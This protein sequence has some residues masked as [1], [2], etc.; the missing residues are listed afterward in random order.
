MS[1]FCFLWT[2]LFY[3]FW[4]SITQEISV[5][6]GGIWALLLG[7]V[8]AIVQFLLGAFIN[9]G[10]FGLSR[11]AAICIDIV[12]LPA[13]LPILVC[14]LFTFLHIS[15]G[16]DYANFALLWLIP[17]AA[18]RAV[19]WSAQSDPN[20][21]VLT[22]LLWTAIAVGVPFF[23][24]MAMERFGWILIPIFMAMILLP[25]L[26]SIS[27][28]AF[29]SQRPGWGFLFLFVSLIPMGI[30]TGVSFFRTCGH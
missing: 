19:S 8:V 25:F 7:S 14:F 20:L 28:W 6:S 12:L 21:L 18:I 26:A 1:L 11:W 13:S 10:G 23:I 16:A 5:N 29:F 2:P 24:R 9:P 17:G 4:R 30:S 27:Y 15:S 22:P 3:L